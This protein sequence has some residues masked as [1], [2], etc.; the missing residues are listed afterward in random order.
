MDHDTMVRLYMSIREVAGPGVKI[1][2]HMLQEFKHKLER[3]S[4]LKRKLWM[5]PKDNVVDPR[6]QGFIVNHNELTEWPM[7]IDAEGV[8]VYDCAVPQVELGKGVMEFE[9]ALHSRLQ[10]PEAKASKMSMFAPEATQMFAPSARSAPQQPAL[11]K[12]SVAKAPEEAEHPK[13]ARKLLKRES[14]VSEDTAAERIAADTQK[15]FSKGH[16][17]SKDP[18]D[19]SVANFWVKQMT[20]YTLT[21]R[22]NFT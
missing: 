20:R 2:Q 5:V 21:L 13:H 19:T 7:G 18:N 10:A 11:D 1:S 14:D 17:I 15:C 4:S 3:V 8:L 22:D 6:F 16:L 9:V 12:V